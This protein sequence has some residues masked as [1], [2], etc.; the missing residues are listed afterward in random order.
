MMLAVK[1]VTYNLLLPELSDAGW[2]LYCDA[3]D[4]DPETRF[5]YILAKLEAQ[6]MRRK[7][8]LRCRR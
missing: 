7:R 1:C 2:Y 8:S 6:M 4:C 5:T 3:A